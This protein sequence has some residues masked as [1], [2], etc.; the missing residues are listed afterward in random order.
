M[1][2]G[3]TTSKAAGAMCPAPT[4]ATPKGQSA[5][6]GREREPVVHVAYED[7]AAYAAWVDKDL[8][9]EVEWEFAARGGLD[10]A[11]FCWGDEFTPDDRYM[12]NTWQGP[13]PARD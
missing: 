3:E 2:K 4:G 9:T 11:T 13:F 1:R 8:P 5:I 10:G 7:A 12:A 6:A